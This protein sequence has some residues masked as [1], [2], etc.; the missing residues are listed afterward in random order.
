MVLFTVVAALIAWW[1]AKLQPSRQERPGGQKCSVVG[2]RGDCVRCVAEAVKDSVLAAGLSSPLIPQASSHS[3]DVWLKR[4]RLAENVVPSNSPQEA[5]V[6]RLPG[7][8]LGDSVE[9]SQQFSKWLV[10]SERYLKSE[11]QLEGSAGCGWVVATRGQ[12]PIFRKMVSPAPKRSRGIM[13]KRVWCAPVDA[14]D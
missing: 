14:V 8:A 4:F 11:S 1:S 13:R 2:A 5:A 9:L 10:A 3:R 6:S 7:P 12:L